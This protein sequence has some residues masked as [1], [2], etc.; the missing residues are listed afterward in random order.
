[1]L[2]YKEKILP[3]LFPNRRVVKLVIW[4]S[5]GGGGVG[6]GHGGDSV[7]IIQSSY[8]GAPESYSTPWVG[9]GAR[10]WVC[11]RVCVCRWVYS[12]LTGNMFPTYRPSL[13][14]H[15]SVADP[16]R[17][18]A[19]TTPLRFFFVFLLVSLKILNL[20]FQEP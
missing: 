17:V 12:L 16:R 3:F 14:R 15:R 19:L 10:A 2:C 13:A 20:P 18:G 8:K 1:M 7:Q 11:V 9:V 5:Y 6:V 4:Q